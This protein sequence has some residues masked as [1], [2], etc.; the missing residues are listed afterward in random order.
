MAKVIEAPKNVA[1]SDRNA[2][3][4]LKILWPIVFFKI[5]CPFIFL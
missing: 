1:Y 5:H 2:G 3:L 4:L